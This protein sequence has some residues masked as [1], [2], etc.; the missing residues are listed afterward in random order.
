M[1][2]LWEFLKTDLG[3]LLLT[4]VLTTVVGGALIS[5]YQQRSWE[6][7]KELEDQRERLQ[8]ERDRRFEMLRR[9]LDNGERV[10]EQI[11]DAMD[12][13][14]FRLRDVFTALGNADS[15]STSVKWRVYMESVQRWNE[16]LAS[17]R[18]R[19]AR[20]VSEEAADE[21]NN[22]ET[23]DVELKSPRSVHGKFFVAHRALAKLE[24][25]VRTNG[26]EVPVEERQGLARA[27]NQLDIDTD[28][29]VEQMTVEFLDRASTLEQGRTEHE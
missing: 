14:M 28:E 21:F 26:C 9:R 1:R 24:R 10:L 16:T 15:E 6:K 25:C 11:A 19:L 12:T 7:Q 20:V 13:R 29:F 8:W 22:F 2:R 3:R 23:D 18:S 17:N 4:F 5:E 27:I